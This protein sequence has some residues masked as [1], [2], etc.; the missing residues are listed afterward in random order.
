MEG[1]VCFLLVICIVEALWLWEI[2]RQ[3]ACHKRH[4][5][6]WCELAVKRRNELEHYG[7]LAAQQ[8]TIL[9]QIRDLC[10]G[11]DEP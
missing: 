2:H 9:R 8:A 7:K 6:E 4:A 11:K 5:S 3:S 1:A 10:P